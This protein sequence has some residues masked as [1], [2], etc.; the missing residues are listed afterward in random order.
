M[1]LRPER[2]L[3]VAQA[4][5][6]MTHVRVLGPQGLLHR[7]LHRHDALHQDSMLSPQWVRAWDVLHGDRFAV[8]PAE[9][10]RSPSTEAGVET[11]DGPAQSPVYAG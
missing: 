10:I 2:A 6:R 8:F 5:E 3:L 1:Q 4:G 9:R 7:S 11:T